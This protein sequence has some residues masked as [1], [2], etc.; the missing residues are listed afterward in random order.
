MSTGTMIDELY[1]LRAQRLEIEKQVAALKARETAAK[2]LI[3]D[4]L[5]VAG[6]E[7]AKGATTTAAITH[8]TVPVV[9]DWN[10]V[11]AFIREQDMFA[12]LQRRLTT[13]LWASLAED[14]VAVPGT[15]P[16]VVPDLSLTRSTR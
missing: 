3:I 12:L 1:N 4:L 8:K 16:Q 2:Q 14:G 15:E 7:G 10:A 9:T 13:T 11:Y 6:L 5:K